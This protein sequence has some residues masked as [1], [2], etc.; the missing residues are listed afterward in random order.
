MSRIITIDVWWSFQALFSVWRKLLL[1]D[2]STS[3]RTCTQRIMSCSIPH[4]HTINKQVAQLLQTPQSWLNSRLRQSNRWLASLTKC[5]PAGFGLQVKWLL[6]QIG[7]LQIGYCKMRSWQWEL[8]NVC[9]SKTCILTEQIV[10]SVV[11]SRQSL[12]LSENQIDVRWICDQQKVKWFCHKA[13]IW[14]IDR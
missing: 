1:S 12:L 4:I 6:K 5:R 9:Q 3:N 13:C 7:T 8:C 2:S 14:Y 10:R 11:T